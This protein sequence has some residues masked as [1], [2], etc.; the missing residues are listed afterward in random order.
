MA[1]WR[2]NPGLICLVSVALFW[3]FAWL[4][5][6]P[7][8]WRRF[9][10]R[11]PLLVVTAGAFLSIAATELPEASQRLFEQYLG[12]SINEMVYWQM[13]GGITTGENWIALWAQECWV[14]F[15]YMILGSAIWAIANLVRRDAVLSNV[16]TLVLSA[17]WFFLYVWA[18]HGT[19]SALTEMLW[20]NQ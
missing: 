15:R 12:H 17:G 2:D 1:F 10:G 20:A 4:I 11:C 9:L 5:L 13:S 18:Q 16:L 8:G 6:R 14:V 3:V 19:Y 7:F